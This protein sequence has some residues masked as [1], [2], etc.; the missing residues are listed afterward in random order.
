MTRA[1]VAAYIGERYGAYL[2]AVGRTAADSAGNLK[3]A[4]DDA[5]RALGVA[6]SA[7]AT[8]EPSDEDGF[9]AQ[10]EY[11]ALRAI[12]R[13]LGATQFDV[14]LDGNNYRL[15]QIWKH[16]RE[17]LKDAQTRVLALFG[18]T[19]PVPDGGVVALDLDFLGAC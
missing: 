19:A 9:M 14:G 2:E 13:D 15:E 4:I 16:A 5:L 3:P 12:V 8:A 17:D 18:T 6:P 10:A 11:H 1:D 7:L